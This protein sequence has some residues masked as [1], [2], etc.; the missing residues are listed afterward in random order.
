MSD[1][2]Y[3]LLVLAKAPHAGRVKTRLAAT[4]GAA[5]A[6]HI[7]SAA[8]LD[9]LETC[10]AAVGAER[11]LMAL[12][13]DLRDCTG[14]PEIRDALSGWRVLPQRGHDFATRLVA[15]HRDAG[16][17]RLV[18]IG[19]DTPQVSVDLL[20]EVAAGLATRDAVLAPAEDGG[21]W[22]LGRRHPEVAAPLGRVAMSTAQTCEQTRAALLA[23]GHRVGTATRLVDVDTAEDADVVAMQAG[24]SRFA[25]A[26]RAVRASTTGA[27]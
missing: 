21:W 17:G 8:I 20:D 23:A 2:T 7:A 26:W 3:A 16:Q 9:T 6:A 18:Q 25:H 24:A 11:C 13:G 10:T 5:R 19:M 4:I 12:A 14:E 1:G 15:A 22:A 27:P